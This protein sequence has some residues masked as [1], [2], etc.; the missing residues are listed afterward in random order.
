MTFDY[1]TEAIVRALDR[2]ADFSEGELRATVTRALVA[3]GWG[4]AIALHQ[5]VMVTPVAWQFGVPAV[6]DVRAI[7]DLP[8]P[9]DLAADLLGET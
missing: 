4:V 2:V 7:A 6:R 3:Q 9:A 5:R 1:S 8:A